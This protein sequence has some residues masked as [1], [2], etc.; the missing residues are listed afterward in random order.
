VELF[1]HFSFNL[2]DFA[3]NQEAV[4][5]YLCNLVI[6]SAFVERVQIILICGITSVV[7]CFQN[8]SFLFLELAPH[9]LTESLEL[10][11]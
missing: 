8:S 1:G 10:D 2:S 9:F 11:P 4:R 6:F 7:S 5:L 3:L